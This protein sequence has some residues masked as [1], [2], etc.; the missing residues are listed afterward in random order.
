MP[1]SSPLPSRPLDSDIHLWT[2]TR[3]TPRSA[4]LSPEFHLSFDTSVPHEYVQEPSSIP[5]PNPQPSTLPST[6]IPPHSVNPPIMTQ[7][8][9]SYS[10][11]Y[12]P[13]L[14][15]LPLPRERNAPKKFKGKYYE[16]TPFIEHYSRLLDQ[17]HV[18]SDAD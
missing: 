12:V 15:L 17:F 7:H 13:P 6:F 11:P 10:A 5:H 16:V 3:S 18:T 9:S 2:Q 1:H 8:R 14:T 4:T